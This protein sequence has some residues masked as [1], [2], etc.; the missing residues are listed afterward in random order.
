[1]N[2]FSKILN[3]SHK[4][5]KQIRKSTPLTKIVIMCIVFYIIFLIINKNKRQIEGF[6][7]REK[8]ILKEGN[9][10]FDEFY[11]DIYDDLTYEPVKNK[12]ELGEIVTN[13]KM[14][15]KIAR[16]LDV[17]SGTGNHLRVLD[18]NKIDVTGIDISPSMVQKSKSLYPTINVV[19][20]DVLEP[21]TFSGNSFT[22]INCLSMTIY[23]IKN[24]R[25][26]FENCYNWLMPGGYLNIHLVNKD[27]FNPILRKANPLLMISP[28]KYAKQRITTSLI[29]FNDF[30]YKRD[31]KYT[32]DNNIAYFEETIKDN[33]SN[34]V[35]KN[36]HILYM[37]LQKHI[38]AIAKEY[39]FILKKT[40]DLVLCQHEYEYIYVLYKPE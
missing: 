13:T 15:P 22:H 8:F 36:N 31:F 38:L 19:N 14:Q 39:G 29:Q 4:Y 9:E 17:G 2:Y 35:R 28:Q 40:I 25:Q 12:F 1:M 37:D 6:I 26:F 10:V 23:Y 24:K 18:H 3:K 27:K 32:K 16:V 7:Q 20:G 33:N 34:K 5:I 11:V 30:H 21:M